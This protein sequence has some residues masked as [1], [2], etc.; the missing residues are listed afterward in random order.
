MAIGFTEC[1]IALVFARTRAQRN[2]WD[3]IRYFIA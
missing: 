2:P 3:P 1:I